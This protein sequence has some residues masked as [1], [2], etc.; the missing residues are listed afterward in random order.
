MRERGFISNRLF[1][2]ACCGAQVIS[3]DVRGLR[4]VFG[5]LVVVPNPNY[6]WKD[7][8]IDILAKKRATSNGRD[9]LALEFANKHSFE[10]RMDEL[11]VVLQRIIAKRLHPNVSVEI[12]EGG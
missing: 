9:K 1:D 10:A 12:T 11:H 6:D 2:L 8:A 7:Q 5:D 3:D 4:E